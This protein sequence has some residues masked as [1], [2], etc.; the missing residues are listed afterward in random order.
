MICHL[1]VIHGELRDIMNRDE[2]LTKDFVKSVYYDVD[3]KK[4]EESGGTIPSPEKSPEKPVKSAED[5]NDLAGNGNKPGPKSKTKPGPK[6][7][8]KANVKVCTSQKN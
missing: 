2:R 1:A 6:S 8:T 4:I 7:R 3:L 5:D